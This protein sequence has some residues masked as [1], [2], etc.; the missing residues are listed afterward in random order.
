MTEDEAKRKWCP[1]TRVTTSLEI[2][3]EGT[4]V[5]VA[6]GSYNRLASDLDYQ[7]VPNT[8]CIGSQCMAWCWKREAP[9]GYCGAFGAGYNKMCDYMPEPRVNRLR[10]PSHKKT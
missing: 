6:L 2:E 5:A 9:G 10:P 3:S 8:M 1:L 7:L 4:G